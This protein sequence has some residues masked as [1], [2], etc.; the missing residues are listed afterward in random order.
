MIDPT[1]KRFDKRSP[2]AAAITQP[3]PPNMYATPIDPAERLSSRVAN[4][5]STAIC[6]WCSTCHNPATSASAN[7]VRLRHTSRSPSWI[8]ADTERR[9]ARCTTSLRASTRRSISAETKNVA[10]SRTI[11]NGALS[12]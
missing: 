3:T 6:M 7:S 9:S 2:F 12:A 4:R 11:A 10:A 8:S 1:P 5:I